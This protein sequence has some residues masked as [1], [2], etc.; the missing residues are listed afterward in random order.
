MPTENTITISVERFQ[1][2]I[3]AEQDANQ[4][5][6]LI[7]DAFENYEVIDRAKLALLNKLYFGNKEETK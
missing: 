1:Q 4:L 7:A 3:R 6:A 5:K 2:L